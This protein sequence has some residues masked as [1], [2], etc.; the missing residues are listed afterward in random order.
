[1]K[2]LRQDGE[3][4]VRRVCGWFWKLGREAQAQHADLQV[5]GSSK[6]RQSV[7][8][9]GSS[10]TPSASGNQV[11]WDPIKKREGNQK[12]RRKPCSKSCWR[13]PGYSLSRR[14]KASS[15]NEAERSREAKRTQKGPLGFVATEAFSGRGGGTEPVWS[16][17]R[18]E[19]EV[20]KS[21]L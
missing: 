9:D 8:W 16:R 4:P 2:V 11:L 6:T 13:R 15:I 19:W 17:Y 14:L 1:M 18:S 12:F 5:V 20:R 7:E 10:A 3:M 21:S